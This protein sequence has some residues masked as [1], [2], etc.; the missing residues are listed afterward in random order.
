MRMRNKF[1]AP[2]PCPRFKVANRRQVMPLGLEDVSVVSVATGTVC[3]PI[4]GRKRRCSGR[5]K[6]GSERRDK[7]RPI[8]TGN[9]VSPHPALPVALALCAEET[10]DVR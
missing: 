8:E 2:P 6:T 5:N 7:A 3:W 9:E 10:G 4:T 1:Q